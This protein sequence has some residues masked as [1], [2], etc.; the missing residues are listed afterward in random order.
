MEVVIG[1][2]E[3]ICERENKLKEITSFVYDHPW[4]IVVVM[5]IMFCISVGHLAYRQ[6]KRKKAFKMI[7]SM[8][9]NNELS[10]VY[11]RINNGYGDFYDVAVN[12]DG[13]TWHKALFSEEVLTPS[14]LLPPGQHEMKFSIKSR[15]G[16]SAYHSKKGTFYAEVTVEPFIDTMIVFDNNTLNSWQEDYKEENLNG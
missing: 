3:F 12:D 2:I 11:L 16:V 1:K 5:T 15:S 13:E 6:A 14:I 8:K 9:N 4:I 7:K 10:K